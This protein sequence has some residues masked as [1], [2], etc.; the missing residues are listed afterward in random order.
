MYCYRNLTLESYKTANLTCKLVL[1]YLGKCKSYSS[2]S[3]SSDFDET[4]KF[5]KNIPNISTTINQSENL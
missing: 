3:F 4:A 2:T 5:R 1:H